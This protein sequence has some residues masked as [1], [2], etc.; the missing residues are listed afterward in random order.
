MKP[1]VLTLAALTLAA[2]ACET[3]DSGDLLTGGMSA[4]ITGEADGTGSTQISAVLRAGG[5]QSN[6]FVDLQGDDVLSASVGEESVELSK[7]QLLD[8]RSYVGTLP[9]DT[10][11]T[12][13][14]VTFERT[15]DAGAPASTFTLP[16]AFELGTT[17]DAL[18]PT[19]N[20]AFD[21][22]PANT[23]D[24][25]EVFVDG[26]CI[27]GWAKELDGDPGSYE[28]PGDDIELMVSRQGKPIVMSLSLAVRHVRGTT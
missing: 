22:T 4:V 20:L 28:I 21:W 19:Q 1:H 7:Q 12:E 27:L 2:T 6:T 3:I 18:S 8:L 5:M 14:T 9:V 17:G 16:D 25:M 24:E 11:D 26:D 15:V 13:F 23:S 10:A